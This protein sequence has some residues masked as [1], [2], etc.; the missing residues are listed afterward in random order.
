MAANTSTTFCQS[1]LVYMDLSTDQ[2]SHMLACMDR[3]YIRKWCNARRGRL[4]AL[5]EEIKAH[6]QQIWSWA[7][8][9]RPIPESRVK[10]VRYAIAKITRA[11]RESA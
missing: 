10:E 11:E 6:R 7:E 8:G 2:S 4:S 1:R 3:D 9:E 5:A